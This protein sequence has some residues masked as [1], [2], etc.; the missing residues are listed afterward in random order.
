MSAWIR[1]R[2]II[3][4]DRI[5]STDNCDFNQEFKYKIA[6][7]RK[8]TNK[9]NKNFNINHNQLNVSQTNTDYN[10]KDIRRA[11]LCQAALQ[12]QL[13]IICIV[14]ENNY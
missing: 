3:C 14:S 1:E 11:V 8:S 7:D 4:G 13:Q 6:S 10:K 9:P 5:V 2:T 12:H